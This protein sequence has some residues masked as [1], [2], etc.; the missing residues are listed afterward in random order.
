MSNGEIVGCYSGGDD[1]HRVLTSEVKRELK[2]S[3]GKE[4]WVGVG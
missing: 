3:R 4:H 1:E 2:A